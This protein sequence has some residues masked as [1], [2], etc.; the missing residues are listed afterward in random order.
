LILLRGIIEAGIPD[1][2][3][4]PS[5][6]RS[7]SSKDFTKNGKDP[8]VLTEGIKNGM[9]GNGESGYQGIRMQ[10]TGHQDIRKGQKRKDD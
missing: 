10:D 1:M 9:S 3:I 7:R 8:D 6:T 5:G 4:S 2:P